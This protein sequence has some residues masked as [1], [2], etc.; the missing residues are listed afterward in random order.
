MD[1]GLDKHLSATVRCL[2]FNAVSQS[3]L[4]KQRLSLC[5]VVRCGALPNPHFG[6]VVLTETAVGF[7][8]TYSCQRGYIVVGVSIR[9]CQ[10]I[11]HWSGQAPICKSM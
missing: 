6:K 2:L 3:W 1:Y 7:A 11:G 9:T 8:A 10:T 5:I 4:M